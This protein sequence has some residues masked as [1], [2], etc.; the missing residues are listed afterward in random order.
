MIRQKIN[1]ENRVELYLKDIE[2]Y[3]QYG[4]EKNSELLDQIRDDLQET[5]DMETDPRITYNN[6]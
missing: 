2:R 3:L 4:K 1:Q 6:Y 5:H